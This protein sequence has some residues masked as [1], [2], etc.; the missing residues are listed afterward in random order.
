MAS[1][2]VAVDTA[3]YYLYPTFDE[4]R[5]RNVQINDISLLKLARPLEYSRTFLT[6]FDMHIFKICHTYTLLFY[7]YFSLTLYLYHKAG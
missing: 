7:I 6:Y 5:P 3:Q 2:D 4:S 1:P